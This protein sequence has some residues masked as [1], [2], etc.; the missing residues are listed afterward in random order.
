MLEWIDQTETAGAAMIRRDEQEITNDRLVHGLL[1]RVRKPKTRDRTTPFSKLSA[2]MVDLSLHYNQHD[3]L[4]TDTPAHTP[5]KCEYYPPK[6]K[7]RLPNA[8]LA[9]TTQEE[10]TQAAQFEHSGFVQAIRELLHSDYRIRI[11]ALP[12]WISS[13]SLVA[14]TLLALSVVYGFRGYHQD[15]LKN[16][17]QIATTVQQHESLVTP[18]TSIA[19]GNTHKHADTV[20]RSKSKSRRRRGDYIAKDTYVYY[21]KAGKPSH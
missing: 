10:A 2:K 19:S 18:A 15:S 1:H 6:P 21:G 17:S 3:S 12:K 9:T 13:P 7:V 20:A 5:P 16:H 4:L 11:H 14:L 8:S